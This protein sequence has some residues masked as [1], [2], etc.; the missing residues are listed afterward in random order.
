MNQTEISV[1]DLAKELK[2]LANGLLREA[3][4]ESDLACLSN[5]AAIK[6]LTQILFETISSEVVISKSETTDTETRNPIGFCAT[7]SI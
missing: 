6:P 7:P 5:L 3:Q 1:V 2:R 4:R